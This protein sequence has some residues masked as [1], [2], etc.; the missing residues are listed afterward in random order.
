ME[1]KKV[2]PQ[3]TAPKEHQ[4]GGA[5]KT[6]QDVGSDMPKAKEPAKATLL[7]IVA[8]NGGYILESQLGVEVVTEKKHVVSWIDRN[9]K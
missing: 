8:V 9:L 1:E 2:D 7:K 4:T 3:G 6:T 5:E